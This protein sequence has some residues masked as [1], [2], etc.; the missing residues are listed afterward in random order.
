[1]LIY[2][3]LLIC[4]VVALLTLCI[5]LVALWT[6]AESQRPTPETRRRWVNTVERTVTLPTDWNAS[7]GCGVPTNTCPLPSGPGAQPVAV[8]SDQMPK[9]KL[10]VTAAVPY[11]PRNVAQ[12]VWKPDTTAAPQVPAD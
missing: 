1:M 11:L 12:R 7:S 5:A 10:P 4:A 9:R 8:R 2:A 6:E 3:G